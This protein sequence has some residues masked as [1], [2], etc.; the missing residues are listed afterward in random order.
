MKRPARA[1]WSPILLLSV[2]GISGCAP[3]TLLEGD[4]SSRGSTQTVVEYAT[5][6]A[7]A[8]RDIPSFNCL[9]GTVIPITVA[10]REPETYPAMMTCDNPPLLP[11]GENGAS[12]PQGQCIPYSRVLDFSRGV[13]Q[14]VAACRQKHIRDKDSPWFDEIDVIAHSTADGSTCWFQATATSSAGLDGTRVPSPGRARPA[15]GFPDPQTFWRSPATVANDQPFDC[16][17]C[18]DND[19]FMFSPYI[20]QVWDNVPTDPFVWY[21]HIGPDFSAW[22]P[23]SLA[24]RDNTCLGCHRIGKT[25]TSGRGTREAAGMIDIPFADEQARQYPATHWMPPGNFDSIDQWQVIYGES[26][27]EMLSCHE[28]N[29]LPGCELTDITGLDETRQHSAR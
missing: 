9:D 4:D 21:K 24:L 23:V 28:D 11:L 17:H 2:A 5:M 15:Q 19:P 6:C 3:D 7:R 10:G 13:N 27:Q 26:V 29:A 12:G 1:M 25:F 20:A 18:H 8:I 14:V 22:Q 16:G